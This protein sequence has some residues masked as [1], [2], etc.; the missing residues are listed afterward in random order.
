MSITSTTEVG[1]GARGNRLNRALA[2][3]GSVAATLAVWAVAVPLA[4]VGLVVRVGSGSATQEIGPAMVAIVSVLVG[5]AGWGL[6]A[7]LEH[8]TTRPRGIWIAIAVIVLLLSLSG[9]LSA[10]ETVGS[11]VALTAM[12]LVAALILI[13]LFA[14]SARG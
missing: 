1:A 10:G 3:L 6:L 13:P 12:H 14:R 2:V 11:K 4:G 7:V 5:L 8:F 9:P